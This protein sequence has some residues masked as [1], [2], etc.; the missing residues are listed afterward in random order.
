MPKNL[1][2]HL[3]HLPDSLVAVVLVTVMA[4]AGLALA[5][6]GTT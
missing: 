1:P 5:E 2:F 6:I 3:T 4:A